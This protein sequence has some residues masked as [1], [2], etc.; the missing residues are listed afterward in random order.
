MKNRVMVHVTAA[1]V[2]AL[3]VACGGGN[4]S[5]GAGSA[6]GGA[7]G[8]ADRSRPRATLTGCL[9]SGDQPGSYVLRLGSAADTA[10][11]GTATSEP[12]ATGA[13]AQAR[14]FRVMPPSGEDLSQHL[15]ARVAINGYVESG[16]SAAAGGGTDRSSDQ[17]ANSGAATGTAGTSAGQGTAGSTGGAS[18][19]G[20]GMQ[21]L[22]A[23]SIRKV[24]DR[25]IE[26]AAQG[27]SGR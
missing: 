24:A 26:G 3:A 8:A 14:E 23:E 11:T 10:T 22:R 20:S 6:Q 15:N 5:R 9:Q 4:Q 25:C 21:V 2:A 12:S 1:A 16:S 7:N 18:S 17:S 19:S 13:W 27:P